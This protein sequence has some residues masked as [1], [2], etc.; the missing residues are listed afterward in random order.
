MEAI[1]GPSGFIWVR[2][3]Y[4]HWWFY[5]FYLISK[6]KY[7]LHGAI[8]IFGQICV[9]Q[10]VPMLSTTSQRKKLNDADWACFRKSFYTFSGLQEKQ[11]H[12]ANPFSVG[13]SSKNT[14]CDLQPKNLL[15]ITKV[16][17]EAAIWKIGSPTKAQHRVTLRHLAR[18][19]N[20]WC[21]RDIEWPCSWNFKKQSHNISHS[22]TC[23]GIYSRKH[24]MTVL[25]QVF[26]LQGALHLDWFHKKTPTFA[27]SVAQL[28]WRPFDAAT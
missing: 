26:P 16:L 27:H 6:G 10:K 7:W 4:A 14:C 1:G 25:K 22:G 21:W 15:L 13:W 17:M 5:Q 3:G 24:I 19:R 8:V 2:L 9:S 28:K 11:K 18:H 23:Q 12:I 20:R